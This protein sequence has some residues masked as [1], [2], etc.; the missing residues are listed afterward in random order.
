MELIGV[1]FRVRVEPDVSQSSPF[2]AP[3]LSIAKT[4]LF[5]RTAVLL[6]YRAKVRAVFLVPEGAKVEMSGVV[7]ASGPEGM[8]I[9]IE[10]PTKEQAELLND[11]SKGRP[12][13]I[14]PTGEYKRSGMVPPIAG[15]APWAQTPTKT[16]SGDWGPARTRTPS[17]EWGPIPTR[18]PSGVRDA[19]PEISAMSFD[20]PG[21]KTPT[22]AG[23]RQTL[24]GMTLE[25]TPTTLHG[26]RVLIIDDDPPVCT[27][28]AMSLSRLGATVFV[29]AAVEPAF[30]VIAKENVHAI[31]LDWRLPGIPG[32]QALKELRIH[33]A[34]IP[35][36]VIS[37]ALG[38]PEA[39]AQVRRMGASIVVGKPFSLDVLI[40]WLVKVQASPLALPL[41]TP[42]TS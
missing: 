17:G 41:A 13:V 5:V 11:W 16:P 36:A 14:D 37:G 25:Q 20:G 42:T 9:E 21:A 33:K 8:A 28:L 18:T 38:S 39:Q 19:L 32:E 30:D 7:A 12:S 15:A 34:E 29:A 24:Q 4:G 6:E 26:A 1:P 31:V 3:I 27:L 22:P 2:E 10:S 23:V 40:Q 35:V